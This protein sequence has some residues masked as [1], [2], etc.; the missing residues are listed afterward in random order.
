[1]NSVH[2]LEDFLRSR[3]IAPI[4][5]EDIIPYLSLYHFEKGETICSQGE[6]AEFLYILVKGKVKIF[7][8]S[9]DGKTLILSFK[10][11]LE[12]IGDI[13]YIQKINTINTVEAVSPV[14][15]IGVRQNTVREF[16]NEHPPFLQF[17]L[18][19]ITRK[20]YIKSQFMRHNIMYPVETRL[21][22]YLVSVAYDE[23]DALVNGMVSTSNLTDIANLIGTSYRH[24]NR[25]IKEF[26]IAGLV[27][28]KKGT[29]MIKDL[30]G[31]KLAAKENL[32]E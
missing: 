1:M 20:F 17:L 5:N 29:I 31:L 23:N 19:I 4:F 16:L 22:S 6:A 27:E 13:E 18:D 26:C 30:E 11:P 7:T 14:I 25:V 15:M 9:E 21:A 28:R 10:T 2:Q 3:E 32:Y 8:T 24:L 12:V